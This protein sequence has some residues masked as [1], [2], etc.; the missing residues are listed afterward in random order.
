MSIFRGLLSSY[1]LLGAYGVILVTKARLL[2]QSAQVLVSVR[3]IKSPVVIRL[4]TTDVSL[5]SEMLGTVEY[6]LDF[7]NPPRVVLD[8]GANIGLT[9]V[10]YANR[11][12]GARVLA[13]EPELSNFELLR[14]N[15]APYPNIVCIH[16]A[17]WKSNAR[18]TLADPGSGHWGFQTVEKSGA[19]PTTEVEGIT[20]NSLMERFE[21]DYIDLLRVDIE[22]AEQEVFANS[23]PWIQKVGVIAIELHD[24]LKVGCSRS[25]YLATKDFRWELHIGE[26]VFLG[27]EECAA[28]E[29]SQR[30]ASADPQN[31]LPRGVRGKRPCA[32]VSVT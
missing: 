21:I 16:A 12:P 27:R 17:L 13:I 26:T 4:R 30:A 14:R 10:Y 22:G 6:D 24:R 7:V 2:R 20:I 31:A 5:L 29:V 28:N 3:G 19:A 25:V 9:S 18:V 15:T 32:I 11:Y 8:A 23:S 1:S